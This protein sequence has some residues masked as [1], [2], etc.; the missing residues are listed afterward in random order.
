MILPVAASIECGLAA[1]RALF[2]DQ[3][4]CIRQFHMK[5]N[6]NIGGPLDL[7]LQAKPLEKDA[8]RIKQFAKQDEQ[9]QE[10][11]TMEI[12]ASE[13]DRLEQVDIGQLK[14]QFNREMHAAQIYEKF[15]QHAFVYGDTFRVLKEAYV[16]ADSLL[17]KI[18]FD[19]TNYGQ[20]YYY[21]PALLDGIMQS[22][23]LLFSEE[24]I[25]LTYTFSRMQSFQEA[26]KTIWA[27]LS[28]REQGDTVVDIKLYDPSGLLFA[29][30]EGL[31]LK[32]VSRT[33]LNRYEP[34]LQNL[35]ETR[36]QA[37]SPQGQPNLELPEFWVIASDPQ[38]A[39]TLLGDLNYR[40]VSEFDQLM[41]IADKHIL[42]LYEQGQFY[43][44][45]H[46]CQNLFRLK[47][48]SFLLITENAHAIHDGEPVNP[49]HS[50]ANAFWRT[51]RNELDFNRNYTIDLAAN[52]DLPKALISIFS[53]SEE[54]QFALREMLY[55]PRIKRKELDVHTHGNEMQFDSNS[56]CL[57]TGGTGALAAALIDYLIDRGVKH[58][59][60][61]SRSP[62]PPAM[63]NLIEASRFKQV[64]IR[65]AAVDASNYQQMETLIKEIERNG[66]PLC[67]VFHLAGLIRDSLI[68]NINDEDLQAV[69]NSKMESALILHQLTKSLPLRYFV[70]FSSTA[71]LLGARG[72]ASYVAANGFL[73]G[74]AFF[75]KQQGLPALS[76]NWG[77]FNAI[78]MTSKLTP[79]LQQFGFIPLEKD[80]LNVLDCLLDSQLSQIAVCRLH[81]DVYLKHSPRQIELSGF[82]KNYRPPTQY[83]VNALRQ[84][85]HAE[86]RGIL[87]RLLCEITADVLALDNA[88]EIKTQNGL[89][90]LGVDSLMSIEIRNRIHDKLQCP[91]LSLSIE[92]FI[93]DPSIEKIADNIARELQ[94]VYEQ[95]DEVQTGIR[96]EIEEIPLC[97]FQFSFW[98][99]N[100]LNYGYNTAMQLQ[101]HGQLN[102]DYLIKAFDYV[103]NQHEAFWLNFSPSVPTQ[104]LARKGQF[105]LFY[106]DIS[107]SDE[108][109][110][111]HQEFYN[112][113][114]RLI[115]LNKAPLIRVHLY[116]MNNDLHELHLVFPHI[117]VDDA[118]CDIVFAQFRQ[119]YEALAAGQSLPPIAEK[120]SFLHYVK[121]N[122][123]QYQRDLDEK[124]AFWKAYNKDCSYLYFGP[125]RHLPDA[126]VY[127]PQHMFHFTINPQI[128]QV[129]QWHALNNLNISSGLIAI[130]QAVFYQMS[131]QQ[132]IPLILIHTGREGSQ[133]K[134]TVGLFAEYKR[135]NLDYQENTSFHRR[136]KAVE[137]SLAD[138]ASYQKCP[139]FIKNT[140]IEGS[141]WSLS[142]TVLRWW[143]QYFLSKSF[144]GKVDERIVPYYLDYLS[145][146][147]ALK[148]SSKTKSKVE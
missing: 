79:G 101:L 31:R 128:Q 10:F 86:R 29:S 2:R 7:Q 36:W 18:S 82:V 37:F 103:I 134:S 6:L 14:L 115:P 41:G 136:V 138:T 60:I 95:T 77:P 93:N 15:K 35:Y 139:Y 27:Y 129:I 76:I 119:C 73:D 96:E 75:R 113:T 97:D 38:K 50:M 141:R 109:G 131:N 84:R 69:L 126:A 120:E 8:F 132:K 137:E 118:S 125:H 34:M 51:F 62:C 47:P 23:Q 61:T 117:I 127:R 87:S 102:R 54:N 57:I 22:A 78:G 17:A 26:P 116:K 12:Q 111:L 42:F 124:I 25:Y 72:Q 89:F 58:I 24:G 83:F 133:Y 98:A 65:H 91:N 1:A 88:S 68:V 11:S 40:L 114:A 146:I 110:N 112:N 70:L 66:P 130:C 145:Q 108:P 85:S 19:K 64:S 142:K 140:G 147:I 46:C 100:K 90:S 144:Q 21:H 104:T 63:Q 59:V 56:S 123:F 135:I 5:S 106:K 20:G 45:L 33:E 92:Y 4:F 30:I 122:N 67:A 3:A 53:Q 107:L 52:S 49:Y 105:K 55:V 121:A 13:T 143:N 44:L 71:S 148:I 81:W 43:E 28:K 32:K 39:V 94:I 74:L 9:W 16:N 48:Q 80:N 99:I